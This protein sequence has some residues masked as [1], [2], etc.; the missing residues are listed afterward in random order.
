MADSESQSLRTKK[1]LYKP[2]Q[3]FTELRRRVVTEQFSCFRNVRTGQRHIARL[4]WQTID[5][6]LFAKRVFDCR[7]QFFELDGLALT[8]IKNIVTRAFIFKRSHCSLDHVINVSVIAPR[9][10]I[11]KLI[12]GLAGTNAPG[13]SMN[14][15]IGPLPR[16]VHSE[17]TQRHY[18]HLV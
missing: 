18:A 6:R 13:E 16:T 3:A 8:Q 12:N 11:A 15:E 9:A 17:I 1:P 10:A 7:N 2:G 5:L 14:R 4:F